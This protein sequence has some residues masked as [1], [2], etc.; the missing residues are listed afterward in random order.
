MTL[1]VTITL[2]RLTAVPSKEF[3]HTA[4]RLSAPAVMAVADAAGV[5]LVGRVLLS[6][7]LTAAQ[8]AAR[9]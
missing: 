7:A 1:T 6:T 9:P 3:L 2:P 4:A 5:G 8:D